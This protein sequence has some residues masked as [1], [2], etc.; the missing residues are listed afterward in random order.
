MGVLFSSEDNMNPDFGAAYSVYAHRFTI[1]LPERNCFG[2][3]I[4]DIELWVREAAYILTSITG[5]ATRLAP[6]SGMWFSKIEGKLIEETTH[7][8]Y[9]IYDPAEF[10]KDAHLV[11]E[12]LHRFG[13]E[14]MQE[15]VVVEFGGKMHFIS[16]FEEQKT[17]PTLTLVRI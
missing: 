6:T 9:A 11:R 2:E 1:Y 16:H 4:V 12:F 14:T 10:L 17:K 15:T 8:V 7:I 13:R 3:V 5:G